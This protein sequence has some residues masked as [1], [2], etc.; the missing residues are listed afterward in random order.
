[1]VKIVTKTL[2][3]FIKAIVVMPYNSVLVRGPQ[4]TIL[5]TIEFTAVD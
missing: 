1:M 3:Y 4:L 2:G 5:D